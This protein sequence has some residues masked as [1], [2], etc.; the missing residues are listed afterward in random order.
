MDEDGISDAAPCARPFVS[1][2][3]AN[4]P[5]HQRGGYDNED[6]EKMYGKKVIASRK[7]V[8]AGVDVIYPGRL[9]IDGGVVDL[10]AVQDVAGDRTVIIFI[11]EGHQR[12]KRGP[13]QDDDQGDD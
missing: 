2:T 8:D 12:Q 10:S 1:H 5:Y 3:R 9:R 11:C 7:P 4:P 6:C 13:P